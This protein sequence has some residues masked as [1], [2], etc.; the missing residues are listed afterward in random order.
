[1]TPNP[2]LLP[3]GPWRESFSALR[4]AHVVLVT[5]KHASRAHA[6]AVEE[7]L[8]VH[9]P[10]A[11]FAR[12]HLGLAAVR[13]LAGTGGSVAANAWL[14][15]RSVLVATAIGDPDSLVRQVERHAAE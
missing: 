2:K 11:I 7:R 15:G 1:W 12:V 9:A 5:R 10:G 13:P 14:D 6:E 8:R 3:R 4:R